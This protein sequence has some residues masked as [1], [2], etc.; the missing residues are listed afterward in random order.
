MDV[1]ERFINPYYL[2]ILILIGIYLIMALGLN[3]ITGVTGQLSL[4]HAAFMSIGAYGSAIATMKLGLSFYP[5]LF[6][7]AMLAALFGILLGFPTLRLWGDYLA[8]T[9]M[10]FGEIVR[11]ML[12]NMKITGG[13]LGLSPIPSHTNILN[14]TLIAVLVIWGMVRIEN[15]RFGR[16]LLAIREDEIAAETAGIN[17]TLYKIQAFAIGAFCAGLGGGLYAHYLKYISPGDFG[18]MKSIEILNMVV[19][20]GLGSIPGTII[21]ATVLTAAPEFLRFM[22]DYRMLVYGFLLVVMMIF[23]PSGLLGGVNFTQ[24][25]KKILN[26]ILPGGKTTTPGKGGSR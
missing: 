25:V 14:V 1:L 23:R 19:L 5:G 2:Q 13:A 11:V 4:G 17:T 16:A 3:L 7:G 26:R 9:T 20:G 22:D 24:L 21:G 6:L 12:L 8:I 15:S 10:G 18:F